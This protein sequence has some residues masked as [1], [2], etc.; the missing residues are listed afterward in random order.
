MSNIKYEPSPGVYGSKGVCKIGNIQGRQVGMCPPPLP[1]AHNPNILRGI[2][3][4]G[5]GGGVLAAQLQYPDR[6]M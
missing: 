5:G 1:P 2:V 6:R 4:G 3:E